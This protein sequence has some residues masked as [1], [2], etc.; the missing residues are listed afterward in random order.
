M[1]DLNP[2][3]THWCREATR[4]TAGMA[5]MQNPN[6]TIRLDANH[7][8]GSP[9]PGIATLRKLSTKSSPYVSLR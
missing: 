1:E 4:L 5:V 3:R 7:E 2:V 8:S 9:V 6:A